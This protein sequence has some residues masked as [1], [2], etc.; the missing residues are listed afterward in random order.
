M[1][2]NF[3]SVLEICNFLSFKYKVFSFK[4]KCAHFFLL[5]CQKVYIMGRL[6][7]EKMGN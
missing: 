4:K 2:K 5:V 3:F 6:N 7:L 1:S